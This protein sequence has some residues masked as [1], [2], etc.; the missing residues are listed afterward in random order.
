LKYVLRQDPDVILVG[1]MRDEET[2]GAAISAAETGHL[3]LGTLHTLNALQTINRIIDFFPPAHQEQIRVQLAF[4][5]KAVISMR[6]LQ[7]IDIDGRTP[8]LE[9]LVVTENIKELIQ[10]KH[11]IAEISDAMK[12]GSQYGMQTFDQ[13][14]IKLV[15]EGLISRETARHNANS[16]SDLAL[17]LKGFTIQGGTDTKSLEEEAKSYDDDITDDFE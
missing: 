16:P 7:R 9:L 6:L 5:L 13:H 10:D 3:V 2:V 17:A 4:T 1:E 12:E 11:R 15:K 8:A 14:L